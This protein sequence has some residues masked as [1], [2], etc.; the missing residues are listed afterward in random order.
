MRKPVTEMS[1]EELTAENAS[2]AEASRIAKTVSRETFQ[3]FFKA[4]CERWAAVCGQASRLANPGLTPTLEQV[5]NQV[6][7]DIV[8]EVVTGRS[9]TSP[10]ERS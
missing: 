1:L 8:C 10:D 5:S 6:G 2:L 7:A 9:K 3:A 4:N